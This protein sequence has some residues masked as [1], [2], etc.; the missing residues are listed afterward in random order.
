MGG[1]FSGKLRGAWKA[2]GFGSRRDGADCALEGRG[3]LLAGWPLTEHSDFL[4]LKRWPGRTFFGTV[5]LHLRPPSLKNKASPGTVFSGQTKTTSSSLGLA[6]KPAY[7]WVVGRLVVSMIFLPVEAAE[8][9]REFFGVLLRD[10]SGVLP[11]SVA[12]RAITCICSLL[13]AILVAGRRRCDAAEVRGGCPAT[14]GFSRKPVEAR[15]PSG[16]ALRWRNQLPS[17]ARPLM[18]TNSARRAALML[19][20]A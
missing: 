16:A 12:L 9:G 19:M 11:R 20:D 2:F 1:F 17:T 7:S 8:L 14:A 10:V 6:V 4:T 3:G 15:R 5:V 18:P 13:R